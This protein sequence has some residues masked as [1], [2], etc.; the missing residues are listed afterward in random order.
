MRQPK[1][2]EEGMQRLQELLNILQDDATPLAQSVKVYAEAANLI[3][4]CKQ[5]L[6]NAK[7]QIEEIDA[8]LAEKAGDNA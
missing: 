4:Y 2:F 6:D 5:T 1:S 3:S 7:L 8:Q